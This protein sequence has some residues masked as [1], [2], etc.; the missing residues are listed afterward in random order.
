MIIKS[1]LFML[2]LGTGLAVLI[3]IANKKLHVQEDPR[4]DEVESLLP[5]S[6]CGACGK[7]GCRALAESLVQGTSN[8]SQCT[9][10]SSEIKSQVASS[11]GVQLEQIE[12]RVARLACAGGNHVAR[13]R[14]R[15]VGLESCRAASLVAGGGKGCYWGC[16]GLGD[17]GVACKFDAITFSDNGLPLV[18]VQKC[19]ACG[20]C[21]V[22]CPKH[23]FSIHPISHQLWVNCKSQESGDIAEAECDVACTACG[24]CAADA[25]SG[26][27]IMRHNLPDIDYSLHHFAS[28]SI[29]DRCPTGAITWINA[30]NQFETGYAAKRVV[31][32]SALPIG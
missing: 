23:L 11:L 6:N 14:T 19:T 7:P 15:Y 5:G 18:D 2:V 20:D 16:L 32:K 30:Q 25:A 28:K 1:V 12:K 27:I 13:Q 31:R 4:I 8:P 21:V 3:A 17:C 10:A 22:A 26:L 24:K 29:I 9:V